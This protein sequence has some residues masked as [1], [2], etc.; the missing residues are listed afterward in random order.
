MASNFTFDV[1]GFESPKELDRKVERAIAGV[2]NYWDGPI[3]RHMKHQAPWT[4]RTTNA[5]N[6]L[7][8]KAMRRARGLYAIVLGHTVDYGPYLEAGTE[9]MAARPIIMPTIRLYAPKVV[10]SLRKLLDRMG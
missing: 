3:E 7:F 4:D 1:S 10:A 2:V 8:A 5:R 9:H 6:G